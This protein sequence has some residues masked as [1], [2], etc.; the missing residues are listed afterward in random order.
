ML[1]IGSPFTVAAIGISLGA[2]P[3]TRI[4]RA[5]SPAARPCA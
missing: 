5:I 3:S 1:T 4:E 2:T